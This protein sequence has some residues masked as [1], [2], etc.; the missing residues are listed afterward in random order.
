MSILTRMLVLALVLTPACSKKTDDAPDKKT[1]EAPPKT[2]EKP[3]V[4]RP[5]VTGETPKGAA[6]VWYRAEL[7]AEGDENPGPVTFFIRL[8][9]Q[10]KEGKAALRTGK[11]SI[12]FTA[13]WQGDQV[14]VPFPLFYTAI[15]AKRAADGSLAGHWKGKSPTWGEVSMGFRATPVDKPSVTALRGPAVKAAQPAAGWPG[16]WSLATKDGA[17]KMV[18]EVGPDGAADGWFDYPSGGRHHIGGVV[19]GD[20]MRLT[21]FD[22]SSPY[23]FDARLKDGKLEGDWAVGQGFTWREKIV[24]EPVKELDVHGGPKLADGET[25]LE[26][27][28]FDMAPYQGKPLLV[29]MA[30]SWCITCKSMAPFLAEMYDKYHGQGLEMVT[31]TYEF[32]DDEAY[33]KKA[34][35]DFKKTYDIAWPVIPMM[36]GLEDAGA[37]LP[38]TLEG[39]DLGGFPFSV[40]IDAKGQVQ[41]LHSGFPAEGSDDYETIVKDYEAS[42]QKIVASAKPAAKG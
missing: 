14:E 10:G 35:E 2:G 13:K 5:P 15:A 11:N 31:L 22:G 39:M 42:I 18:L 25:T 4:A 9:A 6:D 32:T 36:G 1:I 41:G 19:N 29:E 33:N 8:P 34:A 37:I 16:I 28:G 3:A 17:I 38:S 24:G 27:E 40:F 23:I 7:S 26:V 12:L 21:G 30:G 20:H